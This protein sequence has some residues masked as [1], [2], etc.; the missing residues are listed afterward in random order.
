MAKFSNVL[1]FALLIVSAMVFQEAQCRKYGSDI[2]MMGGMG[3]GG[4]GMPSKLPLIEN[5]YNKHDV[6][7]YYS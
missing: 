5:L 3:G 1:V 6:S 2:V 7:L 4:D